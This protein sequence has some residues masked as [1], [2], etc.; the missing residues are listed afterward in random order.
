MFSEEDVQMEDIRGYQSSRIIFAAQVGISLVTIGAALGIEQISRGSINYNQFSCVEKVM[1]ST[2]LGLNEADLLCSQLSSSCSSSPDVSMVGPAVAVALVLSL[3][4]CFLLKLF[5]DKTLSIPLRDLSHHLVSIGR[6]A[7]WGF[8]P[9]LPDTCMEIYNP[10]IPHEI[11]CVGFGAQCARTRIIEHLQLAINDFGECDRLNTEFVTP[12]GEDEDGEMCSAP[13]V[14]RRS[15]RAFIFAEPSGTEAGPL[16]AVLSPGMPP[17]HLSAPEV[18]PLCVSTG[19]HLSEGATARARVNFT[20]PSPS[21]RTF[22]RDRSDTTPLPLRT[23]SHKASE[24]SST[25]P[26]GT[27]NLSRNVTFEPWK[28]H[29]CTFLTVVVDYKERLDISF[30]N[31][32]TF[33]SIADMCHAYGARLEWA[34]SNSCNVW[35]VG[36]KELNIRILSF[37][38]SLVQ[39]FKAPHNS[40][41]ITERKPSW[42]VGISTGDCLTGMSRVRG[43]SALVHGII[44]TQRDIARNLALFGRQIGAEVLSFNPLEVPGQAN[45]NREP[46]L[47][48]IPNGSPSGLR[49]IPLVDVVVPE[50]G[51]LKPQGVPNP[52]PHKTVY[53]LT[54][55]ARIEPLLDINSA[56]N[57]REHEGAVAIA[58]SMSESP[59]A[60]VPMKWLLEHLNNVL[61]GRTKDALNQS[62][63]CIQPADAMPTFRHGPRPSIAATLKSENSNL[64]ELIRAAIP[65]ARRKSRDVFSAADPVMTMVSSSSNL[66]SPAQQIVDED[67]WKAAEKAAEKAET[68]LERFAAVF[69][70]H[71]SKHFLHS[72]RTGCMSKVDNI[73]VGADVVAW[74]VDCFDIT[75]TMAVSAGEMLRSRGLF[76][77]IGPH[78]RSDFKSSTEHLYQFRQS[79]FAVALQKLPVSSMEEW[80]DG[81][82]AQ[83]VELVDD[84]NTAGM[85]QTIGEFN[86]AS[87]NLDKRKEVRL[88]RLTLVTR[89]EQQ[90]KDDK[91]AASRLLHKDIWNT[92]KIAVLVFNCVNIPLHIGFDLPYSIFM[93]VLQWVA[94]VSV[95]WISIA[96]TLRSTPHYYKTVAFAVSV[97]A[98]FP[99]EFLAAL[100]AWDANM[101]WDPPFR[102]NRLLNMLSFNQL[103]TAFVARHMSQISPIRVQAVKLLLGVFFILHMSAAALHWILWTSNIDEEGN[104]DQYLRYFQLDSNTFE[105]KDLLYRYTTCFDW[106]IR[107]MSGYGCRWPQS[108]PQTL[109]VMVA[110]LAGVAVW[111]T[112]IAYVAVLLDSTNPNQ[113]EYERLVEQLKIFLVERKLPAQY[114]AEVIGYVRFLWGSTRTYHVSQYDFLLDGNHTGSDFD[115][116]SWPLPAD[117]RSTLSYHLNA[118]VLESVPMLY[119]EAND[120]FISDVVSKLRLQAFTP[121]SVIITHG[122]PASFFYMITRGSVVMSHSSTSVLSE[123]AFFGELPLLFGIPSPYTI[124]AKTYCQVYVLDQRGFSWAVD[125]YPHCLQVCVFIY[126]VIILVPIRV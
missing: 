96:T 22:S 102:A 101:I 21:S 5:I 108:D 11:K 15:G 77:G 64:A 89:S 34:G 121:N 105:D 119:N 118:H 50:K 13:A 113:K 109:V 87:T 107:A 98:C 86:S 67:A 45:Q 23:L 103:F 24:R 72:K 75:E 4:L 56:V 62:D 124:T 49:A 48:P 35:W 8:I 110:Q 37:C 20:I 61:S 114:R 40:S 79:I 76:Q 39:M 106:A 29:T 63:T 74:L 100:F 88:R 27:P 31:S 25:D 125:N 93:A 16:P 117:L 115:A 73:F 1:S 17:L 111:A 2:L 14:G 84:D 43:R 12:I 69:S 104:G 41:S 57:A 55:D 9:E 122:E 91:R 99:I 28:R 116:L 65:S 52:R 78:P 38:S 71:V 82:L 58:E 90:E 46:C 18:D 51:G 83:L 81:R 42:S 112:V 97:L 10:L 70:N 53:V 85:L 66:F 47:S 36:G 19:S 26:H 32:T 68:G 94:D 6:E 33:E 44:S 120:L 7:A 95:Y 3:S 123:G 60:G 59:P 92:L 30:E 54:A 126:L 80:K